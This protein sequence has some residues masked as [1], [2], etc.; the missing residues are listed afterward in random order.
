MGM[1]P[2]LVPALIAAVLVASILKEAI[3]NPKEY[4][5]LVV[6]RLGKPVD[7]RGPGRTILFPFLERGATFDI[8]DEFNARLVAD[9]QSQLSANSQQ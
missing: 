4:E 5:R 2:V 1:L 8:R 9:Y 7:V 6:Y 3:F